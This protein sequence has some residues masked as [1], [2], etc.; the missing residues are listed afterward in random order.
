MSFTLSPSV[1]LISAPYFSSSSTICVCPFIQV[2]TSGVRY[3]II[4]N[5]N[6]NDD[7]DDDDD[8]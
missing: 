1:T 2:I 5:N 4:I 3:I 6:N 8:A 7:D